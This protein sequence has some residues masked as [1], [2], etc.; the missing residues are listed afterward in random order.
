MGSIYKL[1]KKMISENVENGCVAMFVYY[2]HNK[3]ILTTTEKDEFLELVKNDNTIITP[4]NSIECV[5]NKFDNFDNITSKFISKLND[6]L[7]RSSVY[8]QTT[9]DN[10]QTQI[11]AL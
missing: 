5:I 2:W 6:A 10:L 8:D 1:L 3:G 11:D 7:L 4:D 9:H